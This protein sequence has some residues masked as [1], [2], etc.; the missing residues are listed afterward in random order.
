MCDQV[1]QRHFAGVAHAIE[2]RLGGKQSAPRAKEIYEDY[3]RRTRG[4]VAEVT[5]E[6]GKAGGKKQ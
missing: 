5:A 4:I 2:H 3:Y 1:D 6:E